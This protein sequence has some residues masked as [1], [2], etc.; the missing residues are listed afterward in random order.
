MQVIEGKI[1]WELISNTAFLAKFSIAS[2]GCRQLQVV[3][4]TAT[5]LRFQ[6]RLIMPSGSREKSIAGII[7]VLEARVWGQE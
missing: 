2:I 5:C 1:Q 7:I 4:H 6:L 3:G